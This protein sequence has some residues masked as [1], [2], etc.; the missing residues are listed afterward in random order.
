MLNVKYIV[1]LNGNNPL[2]LKLNEENLGN[3]WFIENIVNVNNSNEEIL[4]LDL[5]YSRTV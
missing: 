5:N 1:D 2:G 4:S 3:A